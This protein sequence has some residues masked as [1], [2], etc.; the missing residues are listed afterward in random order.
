MKKFGTIDEI[1][2]YFIENVFL[3]YFEYNG[4]VYTQD[5]YDQ[6]GKSISYKNK[7]TTNQILMLTKDRYASK[8][9]LNV[10]F[11]SDSGFYRNDMSYFD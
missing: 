11:V 7:N 4:R 3:D 10:I 1:K 6:D 2:K 5:N 9:D 8:K